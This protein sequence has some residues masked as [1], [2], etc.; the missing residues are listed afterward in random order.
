MTVEP[1]ESFHEEMPDVLADLMDRSIGSGK[2]AYAQQVWSEVQ[3]AVAKMHAS[4]MQEMQSIVNS[5]QKHVDDKLDRISDRLWQLTSGYINI[6]CNNLNIDLSPITN[7]Y[8]QM[9]QHVTEAIGNLQDAQA[10]LRSGVEA[11]LANV[12]EQVGDLIFRVHEMRSDTQEG[13]ESALEMRGQFQQFIQQPL[14]DLDPVVT[15]V[16]S[17]CHFVEEDFRLVAAELGVIQ[18]A[19][20]LDFVRMPGQAGKRRGPPRSQSGGAARTITDGKNNDS[21]VEDPSSPRT[22]DVA[23]TTAALQFHAKFG[24]EGEDEAEAEG[25]ERA[26]SSQSEPLASTYKKQTRHRDILVQ[27]D[28]KTNN[29][30]GTQTKQE[31]M[32]KT[33]KEE[34]LARRASR[35][36]PRAM[37]GFDE[38]NKERLDRENDLKKQ[39]RQNLVKEQYNVMNYYKSS[40]ICQRIARS[41]HFENTTGVI[42]LLNTIW[43]A[44]DIDNNNAALIS[45][46]EPIFQI[47]ENLFCAYFTIEM[48]IRFGAFARKC[49][50]CKDAWFVYDMLLVANMIVETWIVPVIVAALEIKNVQTMFNLT[51]LRAFRMVK[52]LRLTRMTRFLR[53][54]PELLVIMKALVFCARSMTVFFALWL[55]VIYLFAV[56][57]RQVSTDTEIG[58]LYFPS[59]PDSMKT[60]LFDSLL[61]DYAPI[62]H[63]TFDGNA[64]VG[65]LVLFFVL[66]AS[67]CIMYML[68]GVMF[69]SLGTCFKDQKEAMTISYMASTLRATMIH[70]GYDVEGSLS[71]ERF[72]NLL[73]EPDF[74]HVLNSVHVDVTAFIDMVSIIYEDIDLR[75]ED[76]TFEKVVDLVLNLRGRNMATV[77]N[78]NEVVRVL[79]ALMQQNMASLCDQLRDEFSGL[80]EDMD[81]LR[82]QLDMDYMPPP[83]GMDSPHGNH[84]M[85]H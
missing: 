60:L 49:N 66:L 79:K 51:A 39:A 9:S 15:R 41:A 18:R 68:M 62:L 17:C 33:T 56:I 80:Q 10:N 36:Q 59:V 7:E 32:V 48:L 67:I 74:V 81:E 45:D 47:V 65:L 73:C 23:A 71:Q 37:K 58:H 22:A 1:A 3:D 78:T 75:R 11:K 70:L 82:S 64:A 83:M 55:G 28:R 38:R 42:I 72:A 19:L 29:E 44:I 54:V 30:M 20:Q 13:K 84:G 24:N 43:I 77:S 52:L 63:K 46:A 61:A 69:E 40:G 8:R 27:T 14:V 12:E 5:R 4:Q 26:F 85:H 57:L 53:V 21:I 2:P 34:A 16:T 76:M 6:D 31:E 50:A 35:R 25:E